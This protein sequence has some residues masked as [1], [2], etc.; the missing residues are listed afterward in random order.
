MSVPQKFE[1]IFL[2]KVESPKLEPQAII[3]LDLIAIVF[4]VYF[5]TSSFVVAP[6]IGI[7]LSSDTLVLPQS[8][9]SEKLGGVGVDE[10]ISVLNV[11]GES[12][13]I[14]EG[15]IYSLDSF[16]EEM[17]NYK[18]SGVLLLKMDKSVDAQ[19]LCRITEYALKAGFKR[20]QLAAK[21]ASY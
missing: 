16:A 1:P 6:G 10:N 4:M 7:D 19:T 18:A 11:R 2:D 17:K 20:I 9:S 3:F 15:K 21:P 5:L 8:I 13:V 14:F 12:M